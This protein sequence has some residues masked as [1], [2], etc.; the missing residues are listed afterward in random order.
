[1][2]QTL[3]TLEAISEIQASSEPEE[4]KF[5]E[6]TR[7]SSDEELTEAE[8]NVFKG[9][10]STEE[11][12]GQPATEDGESGESINFE[13]GL[14][15]SWYYS[16]LSAFKAA[17]VIDEVRE[18]LLARVGHVDIKELSEEIHSLAS[19]VKVYLPDDVDH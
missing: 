14:F 1:M 9:L 8:A 18:A 5:P 13:D 7:S 19:R 15:G 4:E 11:S 17:T 10:I 6:L 2:T 16:L 3:E 12:G